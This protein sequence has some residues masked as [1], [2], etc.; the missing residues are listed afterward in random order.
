MSHITNQNT[1]PLFIFDMPDDEV[2]SQTI[3]VQGE[4]GERG[5]PT[6]TSQ[7]INDSDYTTN[8][9]LNSG[10]ATKADKTTVQSLSNQ[11]STNTNAL[12]TVVSSNV[13]MFSNAGTA[14]RY[15][16][17]ATLPEL[18]HNLNGHSLVIHGKL[19]AYEST[20]CSHVDISLINRA[21]GVK[22]YGDFYTSGTSSSQRA[23][24]VAFD[25]E[26]ST[27][28]IYLKVTGYFAVNFTLSVL[29]S[30]ADVVEYDGTYIASPTGTQVWSLLN[31]N[32]FVQKN[33]A[34][35]ISADIDGDAHTVNGHTVNVD[36]PFGAVFTDTV[37]DDSAIHDELD[38]KAYSTDVA[39]TYA[40]RNE[41]TSQINTITSEITS[42]A[43]G[44]PT[45]VGSMSAMTDTSKTYVL[46]TDGKWYYYNGSAWVAGGTY[47][48]T[49]I[50]S[51][52]IDIAKFNTGLQE[53]Y[54][55]TPDW[56][57]GGVNTTSGM[58]ADNRR[59]RFT[60]RIYLRKGSVIKFSGLAD[61]QYAIQAWSAIGSSVTENIISGSNPGWLTDTERIIPYDAYWNIGMRYTDDRTLTD[62]ERATLSATI[63]VYRTIP[64]YATSVLSWYS[65]SEVSP[66][67]L[68]EHET[69]EGNSNYIR[70][71][72]NDNGAIYV[73]LANGVE[74]YNQS[75]WNTERHDYSKEMK[76]GNLADYGTVTSRTTNGRLNFDIKF[77]NNYQLVLDTITGE[78]NVKFVGDLGVNEMV[79]VRNSQGKANVGALKEIYDYYKIKAQSADIKSLESSIASIQ[80]ATDY[81]LNVR[82]VNHRG[83]N[84]VAPENTLPAYKLS[85]QHG[86]KYVECDVAYTSDN[87]AVLLHDHT[88]DRTS[89]GSGTIG[90]MIYEQVLQYDFGSWK[91]SDYAGT[92]IPTLD[93][94]VKL[95]KNLGLHPYIEIKSSATYTEAQIHNIVDIVDR[96]GMK[97]KVSYISF[98]SAYLDY[99]KNYDADAR[100]GY[101]VNTISASAITTANGLKTDTNEVFIDSNYGSLNV[102]RVALCV[103]ADL[104]LEVWTANTESVILELDSYVSGVTSNNLIAGKV[105]YENNID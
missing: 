16:K 58:N 72:V 17:L 2:L 50:A 36:V 99:V 57:V 43:S 63:S 4:K 80:A 54:I 88:I 100:L 44:S 35:T 73:T 64:N 71:K 40:T 24:I 76:V 1:E 14:A 18:N 105:L 31:D 90:D 83:Y 8:A 6:K 70:V 19:G 98:S 59:C 25:E 37:Y 32:T 61:V 91:S 7:L 28:T 87:V 52:A 75:G 81:D 74:Y 60:K 20:D 92:K 94:F 96:N 11:V 103:N 33:T 95:C 67:Q 26:D 97:G 12:E 56:T 51:G 5:D 78:L 86:F 3:S 41:L 93:Q 89:N 39:N 42:L 62:E 55:I 66:V 15:Y 34:G 22:A 30:W 104:P 27:T 21:F 68:T 53:S 84:D 23:D 101:V 102:D 46:T 79:L 65:G 38:L 47:Q 48:S 10:L 77:P 82:G 29:P 85:K 49:A 13:F 69:V 45:P 9:A